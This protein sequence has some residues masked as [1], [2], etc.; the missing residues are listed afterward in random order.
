[1]HVFRW[2]LDKTYLETDFDSLRGLVR[3]AT[4]PAS[5][6]VAVAGAP[7]LLRAICARA[8]H[9]VHFLSGSPTQMRAVLEEKLRLDEVRFHS[10]TLKDNLDN[11]RRGRVR[12][13]RGQLDHK[14][15][16]LLDARRGVPTGWTETLFG[17]DAEVDAV[18]Y[19]MYA[20][21]AAGRLRPDALA[22]LMEQ[23]GAYPDR[24]EAAVRALARLPVGEVVDRIFIRLARGVP[25]ARFAPLGRRVVPVHG[26]WQAALVLWQADRIG[27]PGVEALRAALEGAGGAGAAFALEGLTQDIVR[28][29][30][31]E[32]DR[33][34]ALPGPP[35][36][37]ARPWISPDAGAPQLP[38]GPV[39]YL[40]LLRSLR[41][42]DA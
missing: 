30:F 9:E 6:K 4:E 20:D 22:R 19:C 1:M 14:L 37:R 27:Q 33:V 12:A 18:V 26:W 29:G 39:D 25:P 34:A 3:S 40:G 24:V 5:A 16:H 42:P 31:V 41:E 36:L 32:A 11:M 15:P 38:D 10:L 7:E 23:A 8:E 17:D 2:D 13:I 21:A 28:R 35:L